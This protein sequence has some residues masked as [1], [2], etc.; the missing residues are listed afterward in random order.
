MEKSGDVR[1]LK[2]SVKNDFLYPEFEEWKIAAIKLLKGKDFSKSLNTETYEGIT[3]NPIYTEKDLENLHYDSLPGMNNF[4]RGQ[5]VQGFLSSGWG[6]CQRMTSGIPEEFNKELIS[7]LK[8]GQNTIFITPDI[9]SSIGLDPDGSELGRVAINGQ[10][11]ATSDDIKSVFNG[12]SICDYPV[13]FD[14]NVSGLEL[15]ML[16]FSYVKEKGV[17]PSEVSGIINFDPLGFLAERGILNSSLKHYYKKMALMIKWIETNGADMRTVGVSTLPY[18]NSGANAAQEVAIALSTGVEY[19]EALGAEGVS[20]SES[21][22]SISFRFGIGSDFFMEIA[23]LRGARVLWNRIIREFKVDDNNKNFHIHAETSMFNQSALD[24]Y[25]NMLRVTTETFS[26]VAGGAALI[27]TNPFDRVFTSSNEFSR[28]IARN[29]QIILKEES[30]LNRII[31]P[32]GGSYFVE[33]LTSEIS[34]KAWE[35]FLAI[36]K[37]GGISRSLE[38]GFLHDNI[39]D[40]RKDLEKLI[41]KRKKVLVGTNSYGNPDEELSKEEKIDQDSVYSKRVGTLEKFKKIRKSER[42]RIEKGIIR[43]AFL[44]K[45]SDVVNIGMDMVLKGATIGEITF[46]LKDDSDPVSIIGKNFNCHRLSENMEKLRL[47]VDRLKH[48]SKIRSE[49]TIAVNEPFLKIKPRG[50]FAKSFFESG[51]MKSGIIGLSGT[52]GE[53]V[54]QILET[55]NRIIVVCASDDDYTEFIPAVVPLI[56]KSAGNKIVVFAGDPREKRE[57]YMKNGVDLFIFRGSNLYKTVTAILELLGV[58]NV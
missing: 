27:T 36:E 29:V 42:E 25:V 58:K 10:S 54:K 14:T 22:R 32:A 20:P 39:S 11:I 50:D 8:S 16:L 43:D 35:F 13:V 57:F 33:K 1:N 12:I 9:A 55:K 38:S 51:G 21:S 18:H 5:T 48:N 52:F 28:R 17:S 24:P 49:I 34:G 31:D 53:K 7:D 2:K 26:A 47:K 23:K 40:G 41:V 37:E 46:S 19:L 30:S 15:L 6:I 3:L 45:S 56:K 4:L 44:R